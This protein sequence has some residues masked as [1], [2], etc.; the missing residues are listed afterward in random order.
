MI[1]NKLLHKSKESQS[2]MRNPYFDF[3][4]FFKT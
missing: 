3:N 4:I 1:I 2:Q